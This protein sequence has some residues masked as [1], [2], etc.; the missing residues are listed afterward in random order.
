M[1]APQFRLVR[2]ASCAGFSVP[3][4]WAIALHATPRSEAWAEALLLMGPW[5]LVPLG[6]PESRRHRPARLLAAGTLT[7]ALALPH[8]VPAAVLSLPWLVWTLRE[9]A[10][11]VAERPRGAVAWCGASAWLFL[12]VGAAWALADRAGLRPLGFD[13]VIVRL[14]AIHFHHAG[15]TAP[16][17]AAWVA[18]GTAGHGSGPAGKIVCALMIAGVPLTALG[19][20]ASR[21]DWAPGWETGTATVMVLAALGTA[22]LCSR[23]GVRETDGVSR[24]L[25]IAASVAL[26]LGSVL[27]LSYAWRF[28]RVPLVPDIPSMRALHGSA[29]ALG[30]GLLGM[31]ARARCLARKDADSGP[32]LDPQRP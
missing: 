13:P 15:F 26:T 32:V 11:A 12:G 23:R 16:L 4:F 17:I 22:A 24:T 21:L 19:I 10:Y 6:L 18:A 14:T 7:L 29:N 31:I 30:F 9:A 8:G 5:L 27:A 25:L 1:S 3:A 20:T 2:A 28:T